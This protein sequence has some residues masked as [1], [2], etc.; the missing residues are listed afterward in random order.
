ML[1]LVGSLILIGSMGSLG[2]IAAGK[3]SREAEQLEEVAYGLLV[4]SKEIIYGHTRLPR[5]L[6]LAGK[7]LKG[8]AAVFFQEAGANITSKEMTPRLAFQTAMQTIPNWEAAGAEHVLLRLAEELGVSSS[9]EQERFLKLAQEEVQAL[10]Q[11][12]L[13]KSKSQGKVYRWG[14]FLL[15]SMLTLLLI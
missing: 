6:Q 14:G 1:Q 10:R 9:S 12:A 15:G 13:D 5:A 3:L 11:R 7:E 8:S 4:L 2:L